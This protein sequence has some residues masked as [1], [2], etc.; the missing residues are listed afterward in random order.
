MESHL[1]TIRLA[2]VKIMTIS[3]VEGIWGNEN[4]HILLMTL[5]SKIV[6]VQLTNVNA[7]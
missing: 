6:I 7:S 1:K 4:F 5:Y 3:S 2:R